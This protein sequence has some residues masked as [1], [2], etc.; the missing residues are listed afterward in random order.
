MHLFHHLHRFEVTEHVP[1]RAEGMRVADRLSDFE[2]LRNLGRRT[3]R[4]GLLHEHRYAR[5]VLEDLHLNITPWD[6]RATEH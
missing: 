6:A 2:G 5:E 1:H 4:D 3:C